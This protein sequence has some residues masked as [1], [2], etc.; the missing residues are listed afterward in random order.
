MPN[1]FVFEIMTPQRTIYSSKVSSLVVPGTEGSFG[2]LANHAALVADS[3]G[4]KLKI[5]E[6]NKEEKFFQVGPGT[7]EVTK[8]RAVLL[9]KQAETTQT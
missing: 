6:E 7:F 3:N 8:N 4:G 5:R 9:T 2:V 1:T